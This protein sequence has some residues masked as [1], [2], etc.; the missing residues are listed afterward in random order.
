MQGGNVK[1]D[2]NGI[3]NL[4]LGIFL[5]LIVG[6]YQNSLPGFALVGVSISGCVLIGREVW[7][8]AGMLRWSLTPRA[9]EKGGLASYDGMQK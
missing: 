5:L 8:H 6:M 4:L 2:F 1:R 3:L 9:A 7:L